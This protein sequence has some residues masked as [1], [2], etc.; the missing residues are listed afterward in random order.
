VGGKETAIGAD[1]V[2]YWTIFG[3]HPVWMT[4]A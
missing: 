1:I 2:D 3:L 4:G